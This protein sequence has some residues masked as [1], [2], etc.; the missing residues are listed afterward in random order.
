MGAIDRNKYNLIPIGI[1]KS[2]QWIVA[3]DNAAKWALRKG[4]LATVEPNGTKVEFDASRE[5]F[6]T[7]AAGVRT[8]LGVIDVVFP[9]LHGFECR[10]WVAQPIGLVN[11]NV[12]CCRHAGCQE[13]IFGKLFVH[14]AFAGQDTGTH[15]GNAN[16][17][18]LT[19]QG[20]VFTVGSV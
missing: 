7:D 13:C 12:R 17:L 18:K 3:E 9:V 8:S 4:N 6:A 5:L 11:Y 1:T 20:S 2:G 14:A 15:I 19:L 16:C 10:F